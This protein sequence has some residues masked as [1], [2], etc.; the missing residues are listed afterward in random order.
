MTPTHRPRIIPCLL[1]KGRGLYK[2]REFKEPR[3]LGDPVNAI[4]LFNE[5]E[6]DELV[7]L[8]ITAS[9]ENREPNLGMLRRLA[10]ECFMPLAYGGGLTKVGQVESI[11][12]IGVEKVVFNT[13]LFNSPEVVKQAAKEHGS[14][15]IVGSIDFKREPDGRAVAYTLS[16]TRSTHFT[17]ID[18]MRYVE[19]L[20][21]GEILVNSID[22]DGSMT[23]Y[24]LDA[25]RDATASV[26]VPVIACGGAGSLQDLRAVLRGAGAAA[27]AAGSL[28]V[29]CGRHRAVLITY[30]PPEEIECVLSLKDFASAKVSRTGQEDVLK[31]EQ[32]GV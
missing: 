27:A 6:V 22:R 17:L 25:V 5:K 1:L 32:L 7:L 30:P 14:T 2:T 9:L 18:C 15:T 8:D 28:F 13:A 4:R 20:G 23:G 12:R 29:F 26:R 24:D 3:Y 21:V 19:D 31:N 16:G 11:L 10:A